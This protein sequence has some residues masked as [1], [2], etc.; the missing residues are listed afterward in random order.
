MRTQESR[1]LW[2]NKRW[3]RRRR[4]LYD[5]SNVNTEGKVVCQSAIPHPLSPISILLTIQLL[6]SSSRSSFVTMIWYSLHLSLRHIL[7]QYNSN[8][9]FRGF[10]FAFAFGLRR[11][12]KVMKRRKNK[13]KTLMEIYYILNF[14]VHFSLFLLV[15]SGGWV[16]KDE[17]CGVIGTTLYGGE[18]INLWVWW[19]L[20]IGVISLSYSCFL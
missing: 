6:E 17:I 19:S 7:F 4:R 1:R 20:R 11:G 14:P 15:Y 12:W 10:R 13:K 2:W 16:F 5:C 9:W 3:Q 18:K 8:S